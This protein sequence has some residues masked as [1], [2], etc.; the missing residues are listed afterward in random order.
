MYLGIPLA[1]IVASIMGSTHCMLM[2]S[3]IALIIKKN[4]YSFSLYNFGRLLSYMTLGILGGFLGNKIIDPSNT[5]LNYIFIIT[6]SLIY[7]FIGIRLI[8]NKS[9]HFTFPQIFND[10]IFKPVKFFSNKK[11][12]SVFI[13]IANGFIPCGWLYIFVLGSITTQNPIYGAIFMFLFWV[14]TLPALSFLP[15]ILN[16]IK[17]RFH[18]YIN[19]NIIAGVILILLG[20]SNTVLSQQNIDTTKS[21]TNHHYLCIGNIE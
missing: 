9:I 1:I 10:N 21:I 2:C 7:I 13:G 12:K 15:V 11:I 14:G 17:L 3:P 19:T 18:P 4:N 5:K 16:K 6:I 8:L 20:L